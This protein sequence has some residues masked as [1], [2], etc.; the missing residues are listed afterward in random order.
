MRL[1][2]NAAKVKIEWQLLTLAYNCKRLH[3]VMLEWFQLQRDHTAY[4]QGNSASPTV[5]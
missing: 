4:R 5:C 2:R 1:P 3:K